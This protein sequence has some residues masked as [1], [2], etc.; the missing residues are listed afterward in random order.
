MQVKS[1]LLGTGSL[2]L[3]LSLPAAASAEFVFVSSYA[4]TVTTLNLTGSSLSTVTSTTSGGVNPSW[5]AVDAAK[6]VLYVLDEGWGEANG[7]LA[8]FH[9]AANGTLAPLAKVKTLGGPVSSVFY[10]AGLKGIA[11]AD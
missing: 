9:V 7:S 2:A 1:L 11:I 5:L 6:S 3:S 10:G 8:S 4:G